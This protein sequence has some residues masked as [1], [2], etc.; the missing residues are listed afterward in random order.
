MSPPGDPRGTLER[1]L[2][3]GERLNV[4]LRTCLALL[5]LFTAGC[6]ERRQAGFV[7]QAEEKLSA[8]RFGEAADL[9]RRAIAI[10]PESRTA[11]KALYKLGFTQETYLKDYEGAVFSYQ[12]FI[13]LSADKVSVYEVQKRISNL[14]FETLRDPEKAIAAYR[15][16]IAMNTESLETDFFQFRIAEA[17]SWQNNFEKARVEF[18]QLIENFPKSQYVPRARYEIGNTY[19]M[20]S[21]YDIAVEAMKQVIRHHPQSEYATEAQFIMGQCL[22][23]QEKLQTALQTYEGIKGRYSTPEILALRIANLKKRLKLEPEPVK[24]A[25]QEH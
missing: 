1:S 13:R 2:T 14:Y 16:L 22:E 8:N 25:R 9:F 15:K 18:Q 23:Q 11:L 5:L 24:T 10:N 17:Y 6:T 20:E 12:E 19:Y 21:K 7:Q 3:Q 4:F